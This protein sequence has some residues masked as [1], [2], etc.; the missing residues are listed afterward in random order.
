[1]N[2]KLFLA[3][4]IATQLTISCSE[5][6][7]PS[8]TEQNLDKNIETI[9][10]S[11]YSNLT[12]DQQKV[13]LEAEANATLD[14]LEELK[15]IE[16]TEAL[17]SLEHLMNINS[18]IDILNGKNENGVEDLLN[19]S[20]TYGIYTWNNS[21]ETWK[22]T[23]STTELKFIF[24]A[25]QNNLNNNN[26]SL[27]IKAISSNIKKPIPDGSNEVNDQIYL[28]SS[29]EAT[30]T[31][32]NTPVATFS[33][34]ATYNDG[35]SVFN[36]ANYKLSLSKGYVWEQSGSKGSTNAASS[37]L[38]HNGKNIISFNFD[39]TSNID[40][41]LSEDDDLKGYYGQANMLVKILD[42]LAIVGTADIEKVAT[43]E[44]ENTYPDYNNSNY[45][46]QLNAYYK[47]NSEHEASIFNNNGKL[48]LVS[49]KDGSKIAD[50]VMKSE[51]GE[52]YNDHMKW[53]GQTWV[54]DENSTKT[55]QYYDTVPY[56][57]FN[58]K[59]EVSMEAYFSAGF[60]DL[61]DKFIEFL[62][63]FN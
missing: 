14:E 47:E 7:T 38:S 63:G 8:K 42:N 25:D 43:D 51:K 27:S 23:S 34:N 2:K 57:R 36:T 9:L 6:E 37:S 22:K 60:T 52:S 41:L 13:K 48:A 35:K 56:L 58:D 30:L 55:I 24:P 40:K 45:Y 39:N 61:Q 21:T 31:I 16:G 11:P 53:N 44:F 50:I 15:S 29:S 10:K 18:S 49:T 59:T 33:T 46:E 54:W 17:S 28:P 1:M 12:P 4:L 32:N 26:A 3:S 62:K 19:I 20:G 5:N